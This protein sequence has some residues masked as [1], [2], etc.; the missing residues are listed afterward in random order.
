MHRLPQCTDAFPMDDSHFQNSFFTAG[1]KV[2]G[3]KVLDLLWTERVQVEH[4][5]NGK[6][7]GFVAHGEWPQ[8]RRD[9]GGPDYFIWRQDRS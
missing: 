1:R 4:T 2:S 7:D 6:L 5:F 9:I 8:S 3:D